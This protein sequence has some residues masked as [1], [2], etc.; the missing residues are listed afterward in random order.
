MF[1]INMWLVHA[2][3]IK[4]LNSKQ[5]IKVVTM[6]WHWLKLHWHKIRNL[7]MWSTRLYILCADHDLA[8]AVKQ[9]DSGHNIDCGWFAEWVDPIVSCG[10]SRRRSTWCIGTPFGLDL[11]LWS[12]DHRHRN[13]GDQGPCPPPPQ[14]SDWLVGKRTQRNSLSTDN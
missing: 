11:L 9:P 5:N 13:W 7:K 4:T 2:E 14:P 8:Y 12:T 3:A 10:G 1:A 6:C